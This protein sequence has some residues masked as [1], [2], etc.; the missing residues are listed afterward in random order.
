M[1]LH[2]RGIL[3][4]T[5]GKEPVISKKAR[6]EEFETLLARFSGFIRAH[7]Q[8]FDIQRFGIDPDD[9]AQEV[10][11]KIWKLLEG[12]KN[13]ANHA[14]YIKKIVDSSVIDQIRRLRREE[15]IFR[16][17]RQKQVTEREDVYRPDTLRNVTLKEVV[18]RAAD[19]LIDSRRNVVKLYLL[20]MSLEEITL[21]YGWSR[22]KTRNLLYRGLS[23]LKKSLKKTDIEHEDR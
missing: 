6:E 19:A 23:D 16:Q 21:F 22:H 15:A 5:E 20:N 1:A 18:G 7:I 2:K 14:S 3:I 17:E 12:E 13:I 11:I 9:V 8:K 4:R 10:R